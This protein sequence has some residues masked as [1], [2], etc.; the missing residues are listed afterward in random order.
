MVDVVFNHGGWDGAPNTVDYADFNPLNAESSYHPYCEIDY[1][2]QTSIEVCW[3][4]STNVP[5][6]DFKTDSSSVA[7]TL[8][9][10]ASN[11][12]E[13][14]SCKFLADEETFDACKTDKGLL[15]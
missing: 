10:W 2:N 14:Y 11:I 3:E 12:V 13:T 7:N 6:P 9:S 15:S 4:G 5:L 1:N 8:Y